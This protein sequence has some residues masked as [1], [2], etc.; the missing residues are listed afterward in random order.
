LRR[1]SQRLH[2]AATRAEG[3]LHEDAI[4]RVPPL[5]APPPRSCH[6]AGNASIG[7]VHGAASAREIALEWRRSRS[8]QRAESTA[9][10]AAS[11][12]LP[13]RGDYLDRAPPIPIF[14][15]AAQC[16]GGAVHEDVIARHP[17]LCHLHWPSF[18]RGQAVVGAVHEDAIARGRALRAPPPLAPLARGQTVVGAVLDSPIAP[19]TELTHGAIH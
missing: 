5:L 16:A 9:A 3:A 12:E 4:A 2:R 7:A 10:G 11:T 6:R 18:A 13:S 15:R 8:C 1:R 17:P 19:S 14:H